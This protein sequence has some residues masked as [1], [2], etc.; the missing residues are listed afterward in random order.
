LVV[1]ASG[2]AGGLSVQL[3]PLQGDKPTWQWAYSTEPS[4]AV[5]LQFVRNAALHLWSSPVLAAA[6]GQQQNEEEVL[7]FVI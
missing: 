3:L 5:Q 6:L 7:D 2:S 4:G 1:T